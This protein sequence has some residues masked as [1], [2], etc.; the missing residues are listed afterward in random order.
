MLT[1][2][3]A[4]GTGQSVFEVATEFSSR[5]VVAGSVSIPRQHRQNYSWPQ[6]TEA[7]LD[8]SPLKSIVRLLSPTIVHHRNALPQK[9][10]KKRE[11]KKEEN[12]ADRHI[13]NHNSNH[14]QT[15]I[16]RAPRP[17]RTSP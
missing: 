5:V 15:C 2:Q 7:S 10:E 16:G 17:H 12:T 14:P 9:K 8:W 4:S 13:V 1:C 11:E 6:K 3:K